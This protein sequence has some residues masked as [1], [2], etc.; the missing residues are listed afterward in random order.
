MNTKRNCRSRMILLKEIDCRKTFPP[1]QAH[2][3]NVTRR[4]PINRRSSLWMKAWRKDVSRHMI[5]ISRQAFRFLQSGTA[6]RFTLATLLYGVIVG[7]N[8]KNSVSSSGESGIEKLA[9]QQR[10]GRGI[11]G[12]LRQDEDNIPEF[13]ALRL[14]DRRGKRHF[15]VW[16]KRKRDLPDIPPVRRQRQPLR[17]G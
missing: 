6:R 2:I 10:S 12:E 14:V 16:Q 8:E 11:L 5:G 9:G 17:R 7:I 13:R 4:R 15:A 3:S 1:F